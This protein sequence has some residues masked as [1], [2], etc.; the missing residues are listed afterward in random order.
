MK[1]LFS[2]LTHLPIA[3]LLFFGCLS[4]RSSHALDQTQCPRPDDQPLYNPFGALSTS[5]NQYLFQNILGYKSP[6]SVGRY[7]ACWNTPELDHL[8]VT[9]YKAMIQRASESTGVPFAVLACLFFIE[10]GF[11]K[12]VVSPKDAAGLAQ[13]TEK[14]WKTQVQK[15]NPAHAVA[16]NIYM[17]ANIRKLT[18]KGS[19]LDRKATEFT[20]IFSK[21]LQGGKISGSANLNQIAALLT[22]FLA[23]ESPA[24]RTI[25]AE[26]LSNIHTAQDCLVYQ[27]VYR[28]YFERAGKSPPNLS[29]NDLETPEHRH[30]P[31]VSII[32]GAMYLEMHVFQGIYGRAYL[33]HTPD[34]FVIAAGGYNVG[35]GKIKCPADMAAT[36]CIKQMEAA[37]GGKETETTRQMKSMQN[38]SEHGNRNPMPR[39][40]TGEVKACQGKI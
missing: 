5:S 1:F 6:A 7:M 18:E 15:L 26:Y 32:L 35:P 31:E 39:N 9:K 28:D 17:A 14:T 40:A 30:D 8:Y 34:R 25:V 12:G 37:N 36:E 2:H 4:V 20:Q 38:C 23:S 16:G 10:S 19:A 33:P 11:D 29:F 21:L 3:A 24:L 22:P 13:F 27:K